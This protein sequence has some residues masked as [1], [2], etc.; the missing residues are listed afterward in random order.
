MAAGPGVAVFVALVHRGSMPGRVGRGKRGGAHQ[1]PSVGAA[2]L[3]R[4]TTYMGYVRLAASV[5]FFTPAFAVLAFWS[6]AGWPPA[7]AL[8]GTVGLFFGLVVGRVKANWIGAICPSDP[9]PD[10]TQRRAERACRPA[11]RRRR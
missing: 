9:G 1:T 10:S 3:V 2:T 11:T 5:A 8:G 6:S 4:S 7:C